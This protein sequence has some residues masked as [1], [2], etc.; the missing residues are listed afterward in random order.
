MQ[1]QEQTFA[2]AQA[3]DPIALEQLLV[4]LRPDILRYARRQ[5]HASSAIEDVVQ[6]ALL[7]LYRRVGTV[8]SA[9]ALGA[10]LGARPSNRCDGH[11]T[12]CC[13]PAVS[14]DEAMANLGDGDA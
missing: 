11:A 12:S 3:G 13:A 14:A 6:E 10:W 9:A 1:V 5:C 8:R 4:Q 7:I 2:A